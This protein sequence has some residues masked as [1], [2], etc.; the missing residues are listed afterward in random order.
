MDAPP[1]KP[2]VM[3]MEIRPLDPVIASIVGALGTVAGVPSDAPLDEPAPCEFT[4]RIRTGYEVPLVNPVITSGLV[5][6]TGDA[7]T[8]VVP[9]S[10]EYS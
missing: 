1:L 6:V 9:S 3:A 10:N 2:L 4:A 7:A 5:V 8:H